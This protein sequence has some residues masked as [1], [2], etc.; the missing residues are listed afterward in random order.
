LRY[1]CR[2]GGLGSR[3]GGRL[4]AD[5]ARAIMEEAQGL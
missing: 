5:A 4:G 2:V 3:G 1:V